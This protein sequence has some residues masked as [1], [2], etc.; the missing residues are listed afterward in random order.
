M[1]IFAEMDKQDLEKI[2]ELTYKYGWLVAEER[3]QGGWLPDAA[4]LEKS[5]IEHVLEDAIDIGLEELLQT[6]SEWLEFHEEEGW[7]ESLMSTAEEELNYLLSAF[8]RWNLD[9]EDELLNALAD[10]FGG[11][12]QFLMNEDPDW[13]YDSFGGDYLES[14]LNS[15][16]IS[17][18]EREGINLA[19][20][21]FE[22]EEYA[23]E[24]FDIY[25]IIDWVI[26][27]REWTVKDWLYDM[28]DPAYLLESF[29]DNIDI[30]AFIRSMYPKYLDHFLG[31]EDEI[32]EIRRVNDELEEVL[33][34]GDSGEK[35][36]AFQLG[37]NTVH[38]HGAMVEHFLGLAP[39]TGEELLDE[40]SE[41]PQTDQWNRELEKVLGH[42]L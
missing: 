34:N 42:P 29:G 40:L 7:I 41:G 30:K 2:Y 16:E 10:S 4:Y 14:L 35:I 33:E 8:D 31:L 20:S 19:L 27:E 17:D 32:T 38:H 24:H 15:A 3:M 18:E 21:E 9:Y 28:G 39:G 5:K 36:I 37:L 25:T 26:D 6:Y 22:A 13:I 1:R 23:K 11:D 12:K